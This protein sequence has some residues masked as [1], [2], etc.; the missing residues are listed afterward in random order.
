MD[1][2]AQPAAATPDRLVLVFFWGAGTVLMGAHDG[3][4]EH[5][6]FGVGIGG[7]RREDL[8]PDP[9]CG[10]RGKSPANPR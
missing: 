7:Q 6:V 1:L 2:G 10:F 9:A 4:V 8:L 3:A 5:R